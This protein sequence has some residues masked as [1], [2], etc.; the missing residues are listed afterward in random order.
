[1]TAPEQGDPTPKPSNRPSPQEAVPA[2][3]PQ[4]SEPHPSEALDA[5]I[6]A[7]EAILPEPPQHDPAAPEEPTQG[8]GSD[9]VTNP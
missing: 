9:A 8:D 4:P 1:M 5:E 6:G 3:K 2:L 7:L